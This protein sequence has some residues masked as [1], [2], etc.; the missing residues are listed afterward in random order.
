[1][2]PPLALLFL[3]SLLLLTLPIQTLASPKLSPAE[4]KLLRDTANEADKSIWHVSHSDL[5]QYLKGEGKV[6]LVFFGAVWCKFT[7]RFTP[8]WLQ[9]QQKFEKEGWDK[10]ENFKIVKLECSIDENYGVN[11][12]PTLHLFING[13]LQGEYPGADTYDAVWEYIQSLHSKYIAHSPQQPSTGENVLLKGNPVVKDHHGLKGASSKDLKELHA[14]LEEEKI[15]EEGDW[16]H[17]LPSKEEGETPALNVIKQ[18]TVE[19]GDDKEAGGKS[20]WVYILLGGSAAVVVVGALFMFRKKV[21]RVVRRGSLNGLRRASVTLDIG[22]RGSVGGFGGGY[23][24][25]ATD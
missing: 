3:L 19:D 25:V 13:E 8:Q 23:K 22:R 18:D 2:R 16:A 20:G 9:I 11:G 24:R 15:E 6:V 21:V 17:H 7:Q 5:P 10:L 14:K 1:M 4:K 12:Y